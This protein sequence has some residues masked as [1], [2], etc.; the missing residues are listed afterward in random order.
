[1]AKSRFLIISAVLAVLNACSPSFK[2]FKFIHMSDTQIGFIDTSEGYSHSDSLFRAAAA[3][4]N[5]ENPDLFFITG[6][7]VDNTSD[8]LQNAVFEAGVATL[9][10]PVWLVP[11]NHDYNKTW[12]EDIRDSYVALRG[13]ERFSFVHKRCAFIGI[14]SNCVMEDAPEAE[15]AQKE[16]L[17]KELAKARKCRH[18]FIFLHCPIFRNSVD[19]PHDYSNFPVEKR[20]EYLSLFKEH[21]VTAIFA[22]HTHADYH[23]TFEGIDHVIANPVANALGHGSPGF[24]VITV[25]EDGIEVK[26]VQTQGFDPDKCRF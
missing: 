8:P 6:D 2:P 1:M 15:A 12:T 20:R 19:E 4:A 16:W 21:G 9:D 23:F 26:S 3:Q 13:Y 17:I 10:A 18:T 14:D 5:A 24:N 22:G 7:L 11:G 25:K